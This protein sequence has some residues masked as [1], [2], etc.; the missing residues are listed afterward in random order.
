MEKERIIRQFRERA[1]AFEAA[2]DLEG[3]KAWLRAEGEEEAKEAVFQ[4][5]QLLEDTFVFQDLWDME[6]CSVPYQ[7]KPLCWEY[8]PNGDPEWVYMLNRHE[9]MKK[10]L[11]AYW[12]TGEER[13]AKKLKALLLHWARNHR[14][15]D[16]P[17]LSTRTIDTGIRCGAWLPL[18][19]HLAAEG[20]LEDGEILE[21]AESIRWQLGYLK[22]S[23]V[24]KYALS[25]WGVLQTTAI[26]M[27][28]LWFED[29]LEQELLDWARGELRQELELQ[30]YEDGSHWEQSIM[31]HMEVLNAC[32]TLMIMERQMGKGWDGFLERAMRG[33][34]RYVMFAAGP[35]MRQQ[36][37]GDSDVTDVRD[38]LTRGALM[39]GDGELKMG[40]FAGLNLDNVWLFGGAGI[41]EYAGIQ[42]KRPGELDGIFH[43]S[44]NFYFRTGWDREAHYT[45][46]Q[47]GSMGSSHGHVD[48]TH[49]S[50][51]YGGVPFLTDC[52]RYSYV[53]GEPLR[54]ALKNGPA[55]NICLV[56]GAGPGEADGSWSC[57]FY[58]DC[59]KNYVKSMEG[60]RYAELP[61]V[62]REP[63]K[64]LRF[65]SRRVF[66]F[67]E[68]IWLII[69]D[70]RMDGCHES[71]TI[72]HFDPQVRVSKR[73][74]GEGGFLLENAGKRLLIGGDGIWKSET[75]ILS[76][77]YNETK[78]H[79]VIRA[80]NRWEDE[81]RLVS[82]LAPEG[83]EVRRARIFQEEKEEPCGPGQVTALEICMDGQ[84]R[85]MAAVFCRETCKGRKA[86]C[87]EGRELYGKAVVLKKEGAQWRLLRFRA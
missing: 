49:I 14:P 23:Y 5:G 79:P 66:M 85:Y 6:P 24:K 50:N 45:Y 54:T 44:G 51:Y 59:L 47:N 87:Y 31:Y 17:G 1:A 28:G 43:D 82:W 8:T 4:A 57:R 60:I 81:A 3:V 63:G 69:D 19:A 70:A 2:W 22:K 58:G 32:S 78:E 48:L 46:L 27:C 40:G 84:A 61:Y 30:I 52:G 53:E 15:E 65:H 75:G 42:A 12:A 67:P 83:V 55:H 68:G 56:D 41:R 13:Y 72:F 36:A 33:M 16:A 76:P 73:A 86:F 9:Y 39:F 71:S 34:Y 29:F 64:A 62:C 80:E 35:D 10:L 74:D 26:C 20:F 25:N 77:K 11:E 37:Q 7:L 38:V 18:M 21:L